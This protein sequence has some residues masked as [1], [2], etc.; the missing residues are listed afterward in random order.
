MSDEEDK[1]LSSL[2]HA[3]T[4]ATERTE[5]AVL[6]DQDLDRAFRRVDDVSEHVR[7]LYEQLTALRSQ[8]AAQIYEKEKLSLSVLAERWGMSKTRAGQ[9]IRAAKQG[10]QGGNQ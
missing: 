6:G 2:L 5:R 1:R 3:F 7:K 8:I 9:I 10:E 4:A